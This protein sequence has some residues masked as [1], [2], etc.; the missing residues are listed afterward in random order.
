MQV[1]TPFSYISKYVSE[2][3]YYHDTKRQGVLLGMTLN[4]Y[5]TKRTIF[6]TQC[7]IS[8]HCRKNSLE[9]ERQIIGSSDQRQVH[10]QKI[11]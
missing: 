4:P 5:H 1:H 2:S 10:I 8:V 9:E 3:Y 6:R 11:I 7:E